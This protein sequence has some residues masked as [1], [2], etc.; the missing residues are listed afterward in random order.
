MAVK[1][2]CQFKIKSK[3]MEKVAG[4]ELE[5]IERT[6]RFKNE[7]QKQKTRKITKTNNNKNPTYLSLGGLRDSMQ[8]CSHRD[9]L[10]P[11]NHLKNKD[12]N[13]LRLS[14]HKY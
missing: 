9:K 4:I 10:T 5:S 8:S 14:S 13:L 1:E 3:P 6:S 11:I 12:K 7:I 2:G